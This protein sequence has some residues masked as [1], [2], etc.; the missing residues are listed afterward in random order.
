MQPSSLLEEIASIR[1][2]SSCGANARLIK[3]AHAV[4]AEKGG[5]IETQSVFCTIS[6]KTG[7]K[8]HQSRI[9]R[10]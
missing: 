10:F 7:L 8:S 9:Q 2:G 3:R 4:E 1:V 6:V 5:E